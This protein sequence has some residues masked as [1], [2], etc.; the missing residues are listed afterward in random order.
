MCLSISIPVPTGQ[1]LNSW[2]TPGHPK[3]DCVAINLK[4]PHQGSY[5]TFQCNETLAFVCVTRKLENEFDKGKNPSILTSICHVYMIMTHDHMYI[6]MWLDR[7]LKSRSKFNCHAM[8]QNH[9][10][11]QCRF[12]VPWDHACADI[13]VR[14]ALPRGG[15]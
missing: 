3:Y 2:W 1:V 10:V 5:I 11:K 9:Q 15:L 4:P 7:C 13:D 12:K 8:V 14:Q 6:Y